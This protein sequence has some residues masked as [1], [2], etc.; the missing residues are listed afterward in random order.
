MLTG[1][2]AHLFFLSVRHRNN[3]WLC[4]ERRTRRHCRRAP[5]LELMSLYTWPFT[6]VTV[7][8]AKRHVQ[9]HSENTRGSKSMG[10]IN[11][12]S[13]SRLLYEMIVHD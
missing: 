4:D 10:T 11:T 3:P 2:C 13:A 7:S 9:R 6:R 8:N 1:R 5:C 12:S